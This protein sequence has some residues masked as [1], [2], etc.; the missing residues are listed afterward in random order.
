MDRAGAGDG[1]PGEEGHGTLPRQAGQR[2][3][4]SGGVETRGK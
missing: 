3:M 2:L 1:R 4:D